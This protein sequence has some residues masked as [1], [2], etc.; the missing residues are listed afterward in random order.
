[1][2]IGE[3]NV[4]NGV[5]LKILEVVNL[6]IYHRVALGPMSD[7]RGLHVNVPEDD[8]MTQQWIFM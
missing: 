7:M 4:E 6:P 8:D 2:D 3:A 1:M 5:E